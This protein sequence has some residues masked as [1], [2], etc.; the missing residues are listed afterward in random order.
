R[1]LEIFLKFTRATSHAHPHLRAATNNY[2]ELLTEM[3]RSETQILAELEEIGR[4][5][6]MSVA[7]GATPGNEPRPGCSLLVELGQLAR[8]LLGR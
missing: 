6:G 2:A 4:Q 5:F 3:G 8:K 1:H 7:G